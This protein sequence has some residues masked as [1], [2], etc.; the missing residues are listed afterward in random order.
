MRPPL[1]RTRLSRLLVTGLL[2]GVAP[3]L[4]PGP[5]SAQSPEKARAQ[6]P[7]QAPAQAPAATPGTVLS[8]TPPVTPF[9]AP[10]A[11]ASEALQAVP[12]TLEEALTRGHQYAPSVVQAQGNLRSAQAAERSALGNYLPSLS[13]TAN[14]SLSSANRFNPQT[15]TPVT[16]SATA[17]SAGLNAGWDVFTGFRRGAER[18]QAQ[19]NLAAADSTLVQQRAQVAFAVAQAFFDEQR[20]EELVAVSRAQ[21][22]RAQQGVAAAERRAGVGNATRSD[23]L[24]A[25]LELNTAREA[26]R[27]TET[28]RVGAA[29][30]L[31]RLVGLDGP[32]DAQLDGPPTPAPLPASGEELVASLVRE[33]PGVRAAEEGVK[34]AGAGLGAARSQYFPQVRLNG[35]YSWYNQELSPATGNGS[36]QVGL[37]L[38]LPI[39]DG[40]ARDEAV[41]RAQAQQAT[42]AAQLEDTRR[43]L[44]SDASRLLAEVRLQQDRIGFAEQAVA[45][46]KEDLRVQQERY[47]LGV[48]TMLDLL[49]S[50][51]ALVQA[52]RSLV[53]ARFDS[54]LAR[55]SLEALAGRSL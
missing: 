39:F 8:A 43:Q 44:R 30:A 7:A 48:T 6:T 28:Q 16:G 5:A 27:Q 31:G 3:V 32:A 9:T 1:P 36:W 17:Y 52:E 34:A 10:A 29:F 47:R 41:V 38:S 18:A 14:S 50:Q 4:V 12:L 35:G 54:Q 53:T 49:T 26:L 19:A 40:F 46:A 42:A 11:P 20:A 15:N 37:G 24:R 51:G 23:V 2:A 22:E 25:Q 21:L 45:V 33:A 13:A 55:A